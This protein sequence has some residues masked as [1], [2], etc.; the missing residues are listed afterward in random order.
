MQ[1]DYVLGLRTLLRRG[2]SLYAGVF[3]DANP[4]PWSNPRRMSAA[5][6]REL[7]CAANGWRAPLAQPTLDGYMTDLSPKHRARAASPHQWCALTHARFLASQVRGLYRIVLVCAAF[8]ALR[9]ERGR[10]DDGVVV[11]SRGRVVS[12]TSHVSHPH[13]AMD[14]PTR[15]SYGYS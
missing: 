3:S 5:Q 1:R 7:F 6:L 9:L 8:R 11:Q 4:D 10:L 13:E 2:G 12:V 14:R 15:N